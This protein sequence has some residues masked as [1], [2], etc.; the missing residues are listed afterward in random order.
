M[1]SFAPQVAAPSEPPPDPTK[2]VKY[3]L[4]MILGM[5]DF[6][7]EYA[8]LSGRDQWM[9]RDLIGY[10]TVCGLQVTKEADA[11]GLRV[12]VTEG[13]AVTPRGQLVR[14]PAPQCAYLNDWLKMQQKQQSQPDFIKALGSL[15]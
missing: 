3:T 13:V 9:A 12:A 15:Q 6:N 2:H 10:G 14:V 8:Y 5:D 11:K 4:G 7:Q 1:S